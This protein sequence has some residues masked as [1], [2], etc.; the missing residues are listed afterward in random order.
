MN[1][2]KKI[3][4]SEVDSI[5]Y[6]GI[7]HVIIKLSNG[8]MGI[9]SSSCWAYPGATHA[10]INKFKGYIKPGPNNILICETSSVILDI[11]SPTLFFL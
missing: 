5:I 10:V 8:L 9:G 7:N 4:I 11:I 3:T 2:D 1:K 6:K